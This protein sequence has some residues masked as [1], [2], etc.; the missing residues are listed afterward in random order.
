[1]MEQ[2]CFCCADIL[3][4]THSNK[5]ADMLWLCTYIMT[6]VDMDNAVLLY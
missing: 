6:E 3:V 1:M 2:T 5:A 4:M